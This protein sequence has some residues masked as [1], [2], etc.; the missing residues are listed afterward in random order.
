MS[1]HLQVLALDHI[2]AAYPLVLI[3]IAS[4]LVELHDCKIR[5]VVLLLKPFHQRFSCFRIH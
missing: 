4:T 5:M 2:V 1:C 3:V